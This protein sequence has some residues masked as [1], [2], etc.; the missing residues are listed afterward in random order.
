MGPL[1]KP[2]RP[3][4]MP[5]PMFPACMRNKSSLGSAEVRII[6]DEK[7]MIDKIHVTKAS[8]KEFGDA[9]VAAV[10]NWRFEPMTV[11]GKPT[12]VLFIQK[13]TFKY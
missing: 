2:P 5:A 4:T 7:G 11:K 13:F 3:L 12:K 10:L 6:I 8:E 9:A 1:D